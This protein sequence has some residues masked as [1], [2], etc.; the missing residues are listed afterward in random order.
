MITLTVGSTSVSI[1]ET[2]PIRKSKTSRYLTEFIPD[3]SKL[4]IRNL[5]GEGMKIELEGILTGANYLTD[6]NQLQAWH[7][8]ATQVSYSDELETAP[9]MIVTSLRYDLVPGWVQ[10]LRVALTLHEA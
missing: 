7:V 5:G 3:A 10:R 6:K 8:S 2:G 4:Y 9:A 1:Q